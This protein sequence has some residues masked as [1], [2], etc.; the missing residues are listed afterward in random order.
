MN[1]P[2]PFLNWIYGTQKVRLIFIHITLAL[3]VWS[4]S[5]DQPVKPWDTVGWV[6]II[7]PFV[8]YWSGNLW[9]WTVRL[10]R[11]AVK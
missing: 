11:G 2:T 9:Y 4:L 6:F 5:T 7:V 10:K 8:L 1:K 3:M